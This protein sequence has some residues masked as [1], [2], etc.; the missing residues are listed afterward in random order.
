MEKEFGKEAYV[1]TSVLFEAIGVN[2]EAARKTHTSM[3]LSGNFQASGLLDKRTVVMYLNEYAK[4]HSRR[5]KEVNERCL[6]FLSNI[7]SVFQLEGN[8][9]IPTFSNPI[10]NHVSIP[11]PVK[12]SS[13]SIPNPSLVSEKE[14]ELESL[15]QVQIQ[16]N[17]ELE[18]ELELKEKELIKSKSDSNI[19]LF[20]KELELKENFE[21]ELDSRLE[22]ALNTGSKVYDD[23][24]REL[25]ETIATLKSDHEFEIRQI[26]SQVD[27]HKKKLDKD[28]DSFVIQRES[29]LSRKALIDFNTSFEVWKRLGS[30]KLF[31]V[32]LLSQVLGVVGFY[33]LF[34]LF[35]LF[36]G[37][38]VFIVFL[39]SVETQANATMKDSSLMARSMMFAVETAF[40]VFAHQPFIQ[41]Y[42]EDNKLPTLGGVSYQF[43]GW[44]LAVVISVFSFYS[45][46]QIYLKNKDKANV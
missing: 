11:N 46:Y 10:P 26:L 9:P 6:A 25:K 17:R 4:P 36:M 8:S 12:K 14:K 21:K 22:K 27:E 34:G 1:K 23:R 7:E 29:E 38:V 16:K 2:L 35:G 37:L 18:K 40:L 5:D 42:T 19:L 28:F 31:Y 44:L 41:K 30:D 24:L 45:I 32:A 39:D 43:H 13:F 20:Q 3:G 33:S 15:F